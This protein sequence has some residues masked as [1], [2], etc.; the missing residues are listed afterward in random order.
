MCFEM[1]KCPCIFFCEI[2]NSPLLLRSLQFNCCSC[3]VI[4][5]INIISGGKE[6]HFL[7]HYSLVYSRG[8]CVFILGNLDKLG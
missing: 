6:E 4:C 7:C 8:L 1:R 2:L 3:P 5:Q